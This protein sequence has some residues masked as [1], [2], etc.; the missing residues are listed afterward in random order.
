M[1]SSNILYVTDSDIS[2]SDEHDLTLSVQEIL[3]E[4]TEEEYQELLDTLRTGDVSTGTRFPLFDILWKAI[5]LPGSESVSLME[6]LIIHQGI[7]QSLTDNVDKIVCDMS[8]QEYIRPVLD[9]ADSRGITTVAPDETSISVDNRKQKVSIGLNILSTTMLILFD[10]FVNLILSVLGLVAPNRSSEPEFVFFPYPGRLNSTQSVIDAAGFQYIVVLPS[11]IT[12]ELLQRSDRSYPYKESPIMCSSFHSAG[13]ALRQCR[14]AVKII[15][16]LLIDR[17]GQKELNKYLSDE[18]GVASPRSVEYAWLKN[19]PSEV[20]GLLAALSTKQIYEQWDI[21]GMLIG[22]N[23]TRDRAFLYIARQY[24]IE[25]YYI[26]HSIVHSTRNI[27]TH[28]PDTT[29]FVES[30]FAVKYLREHR[31]VET[32]PELVPLGRPYFENL[33]Q[34][35]SNETVDCSEK[36]T[37]TLAT[38]DQST[39]AREAFVT[40]V[41]TAIEEGI[42]KNDVVSVIIKPHPN[43]GLSLYEQSLKNL[44]LDNIT[45]IV[46][47]ESTLF[48]TIQESDLV[49]TVN[50]NVGLESMI[51]GVPCACVTLFEP[52]IPLYPYAYH[53][54]VPAL[55]SGLE[56]AQFF[57]ELDLTGINRLQREQKKHTS[58]SYILE[59]DIGK[60]IAEYIRPC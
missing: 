16:E 6:L 33:L 57:D 39:R 19:S 13:T 4:T 28:H 53:E 52:W 10:Q 54:S 58:D 23:S 48:E 49:I 7:N 37:I 18:V 21:E 12:S 43:E 9:I 47:R 36:I 17:R 60:N 24:E 42:A 2:Y 44:S 8:N 50:S 30:E 11:L 34:Y 1:S 41:L 55:S 22:G 40:T 59:S 35:R 20:R 29:M 56:V 31:L 46:V 5:V 15:Y 3:D 38:Q 27:Y 26:P 32:L 51:I 25:T 45:N 14:F